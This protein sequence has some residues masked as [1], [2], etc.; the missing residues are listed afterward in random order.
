MNI[1][2]IDCMLSIKGRNI[3]CKLRINANSPSTFLL[4]LPDLP[5]YDHQA[6][7]PLLERLTAEAERNQYD[8]PSIILFDFPGCGHSD[9]AEHPTE[10]YTIDNF[11]EVTAF[12]IEHIRLRCCPADRV[13]NLQIYCESFGS[14]VAMSLVP[15]RPK[16]MRHGS[17]IRLTQIISNG[18]I[19]GMC[20]AE[21]TKDWLFQRYFYH[22]RY[23]SLVK[24]VSKLFNGEIA[25]TEDYLS[26][27]AIPLA[28][29]FSRAYTGM[30]NSA[31]GST[32]S[33]YPASAGTI[34]R[35]LRYIGIILGKDVKAIDDNLHHVNSVSI[36]VMKHFFAMRFHGVDVLKSVTDHQHLYSGTHILMLTGAEDCF[37]NSINVMA[38]QQKLRHSSTLI[39]LNDRHLT[40]TS[41]GQRAVEKILLLG[42][43][44]RLNK[45][46]MTDPIINFSCLPDVKPKEEKK[47][48]KIFTCST[49][50]I[51]SA[52][53]QVTHLATTQVRVV[54]SANDNSIRRPTAHKP[55]Q[56][57]A[58]D[59]YQP[60]T[61]DGSEIVITKKRF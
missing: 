42:I 31:I 52:T 6:S 57:M 9:K 3:F 58:S 33:E 38:V 14:L 19:C 30:P 46:N 49:S 4:L 28:P 61:D 16:W 43:M 20:D 50:M 36:D 18:G 1:R 44:K 10:E 25:D 54:S 45:D 17:D 56:K 35:L 8:L 24:A 53:G 39:V 34:L 59:S 5:G 32:L 41:A 11:A 40:L 2:N 55:P 22:R 27:I 23:E 7:L 48:T 26:E 60:I 37:V 51:N 13:M 29:L 21:Y 12:V 15:R 47:R